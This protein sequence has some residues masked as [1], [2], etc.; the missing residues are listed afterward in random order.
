MVRDIK[1]SELDNHRIKRVKEGEAHSTIDQEIDS[2][3]TVVNKT[4]D[5]DLVGGDTLKK[6][7]KA[8]KYL[9]GKRRNSNAMERVL[10]PAE[11]LNLVGHAPTHLKPILW[12]G[13]STGMREGEILNLPW[14]RLSLKERVI[15]P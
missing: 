9:T 12:T 7:K 4:F 6:F 8:K 15:S 3:K 1:P 14:K 11:F 10:T 2:A 13:H 5:D